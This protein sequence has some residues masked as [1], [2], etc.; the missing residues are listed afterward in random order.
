MTPTTVTS[1]A[2]TAPSHAQKIAEIN[3]N[4]RPYP[5]E[6]GTVMRYRDQDFYLLGAA[7]DGFLKS[8]RGP[9]ADV[10]EMLKAEVFKPIGILHAPA[11]RTREAGGRDG[12]VWFNAGYYPTLDDLAKIA[13]LYQAL[14][15]QGGHQILHRQLTA[16]LL[17]AREAI[18]KNGD[19]P[20]T[21]RPPESGDAGTELYKMG[22]HFR[23]YVGSGTHQLRYLPMMSGSGEN[24][25]ILY[26]NGLISI[27]MAKA[28]QLP[29][30]EQA[31]SDAG[32]QTVRAVDRVAPF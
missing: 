15:A 23:P 17:A 29:K 19:S 6:P 10:W 8:V 26:P 9:E 22:F 21:L 28:A 14:G 12:L 27:V 16:G 25:I 1:T 32:P 7:I 4:L 30:E 13:M 3:A 31:K 18:Q 24:E 2:T 20:V 11:V 5:W